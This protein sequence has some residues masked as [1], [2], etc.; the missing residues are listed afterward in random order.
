MKKGAVVLSPF[1]DQFINAS[2]TRTSQTISGCLRG[3]SVSVALIVP[4]ASSMRLLDEIILQ[5][6]ALTEI[7]LRPNSRN[8]DRFDAQH[9]ARH[10]YIYV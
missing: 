5:K 2:K 9:F 3:A 4:R 6:M 1:D 10:K 7:R 8:L